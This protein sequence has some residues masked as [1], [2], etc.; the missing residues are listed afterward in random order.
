MAR[1]LSRSRRQVRKIRAHFCF[2]KT[3][4]CGAALSLRPQPGCMGGRP[5]CV[6]D[7]YKIA[8]RFF[9]SACT[10]ENKVRP[11]PRLWRASR[12][13]QSLARPGAIILADC[14]PFLF[15]PPPEGIS[16]DEKRQLPFV[17]V[18]IPFWLRDVKR[19]P[20]GFNHVETVL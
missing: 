8:P 1:G 18:I 5:F 14:S 10:V 12:P 9:R 2:A 19:I 17:R 3:G 15:R 20:G 6:K 4:L 13:L 7:A 11:T 16:A